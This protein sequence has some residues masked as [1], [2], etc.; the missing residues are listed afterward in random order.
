MNEIAEIQ[1]QAR[2]VVD[3]LDSEDVLEHS[4]LR[5]HD[6]SRL[7]L[8]AV[9]YYVVTFAAF[10]IGLYGVFSLLSLASEEFQQSV[11]LLSSLR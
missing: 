2:L 11:H 3:G 8:V 1:S 9:A 6:D 5:Y 10:A 7:R 4:E